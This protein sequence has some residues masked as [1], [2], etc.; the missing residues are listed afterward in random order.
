MTRRRWC[1]LSFGTGIGLIINDHYTR[2]PFNAIDV[3]LLVYFHPANALQVLR[4]AAAFVASVG[5]GGDESPDA[6][7]LVMLE[8]AGTN[9]V[10]LAAL[11]ECEDEYLD[12]ILRTEPM[13]ALCAARLAAVWPFFIFES[14]LF[15]LL[16]ATA[17]P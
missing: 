4:D 11:L 8:E 7:R 2:P 9:A 3:A 1:R 12:D 13:E 10:L 6:P 17:L 15:L 14:T 16:Y 5:D